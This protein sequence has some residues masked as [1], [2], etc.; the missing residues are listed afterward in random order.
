MVELNLKHPQGLK[1]A[2]DNFLQVL[3][4]AVI[5]DEANRSCEAIASAY[6]RCR[7]NVEEWRKLIRLDEEWERGDK[8]WTRCIY[9]VWP[10]F[11]IRAL[12]DRSVMT[13]KADAAGRSYEAN[14]RNIVWGVVDSGVQADHPHFGSADDPSKHLL[15]HPEVADL[16]RDFT[17]DSASAASVPK[18]N[19]A[20][21]LARPLRPRHARRRDHH[22]PGAR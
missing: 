20:A 13:V 11:K 9:R 1:G 4:P 22:G 15:H 10:D 2:A 5:P 16:H 17:Q 6:F 14:G 7:F 3:L 8:K 12:V 18:S 21:A 19:I